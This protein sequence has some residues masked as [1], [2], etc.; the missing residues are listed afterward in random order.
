[1]RCHLIFSWACV[2]SGCKVSICQGPP[3]AN[4]P[5]HARN[6]SHSPPTWIIHYSH[7][8][9]SPHWTL[10]SQRKM[11]C[12]ASQTG[13]LTNVW[14]S[15]FG[16]PCLIALLYFSL[17]IHTFCCSFVLF[18]WLSGEMGCGKWSSMQLARWQERSIFFP[19][20]KKRN[21]YSSP[22]RFILLFIHYVFLS[23]VV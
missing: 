15:C 20:L 17:I 10:F 9:F 16:C 4:L 11:S 21:I 5:L 14:G 8:D 1:M 23:T 18:R 13:R 12:S 3:V 22:V 7:T 2:A 19:A 6:W